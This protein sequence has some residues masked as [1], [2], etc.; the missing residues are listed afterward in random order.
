[1]DSPVF[2]SISAGDAVGLFKGAVQAFDELFEGAEF[3]GDFIVVRKSDDLRDEDL[4][5]FF[6]LEL[7]GGQR[8]C[9]VSVRNEFQGFA[10][11]F[12][13]FIESHAHG[14]DAGTDIPGSGD[15]IPEYGAGHLVHDE[16]D[17]GFY[18]FDFDVGL[19]GSQVV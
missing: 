14:E 3:F 7:L 17:I 2:S 16:P 1:M 9:A 6:N 19:I 13:E 8:I 15:L 4:P 10:W 18:A 12:L 11:E 5:V